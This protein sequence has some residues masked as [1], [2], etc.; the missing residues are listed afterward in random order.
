[1]N[2]NIKANSNLAHQALDEVVDIRDQL[3]LNALLQCAAVRL[4]ELYSNVIVGH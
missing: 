3:I 4:K 2:V 1:L